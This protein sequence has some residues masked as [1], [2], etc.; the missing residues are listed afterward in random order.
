M[1]FPK[2]FVYPLH[3][4][5]NM[6]VFSKVYKGIMEFDNFNLINKNEF[7]DLNKRQRQNKSVFKAEKL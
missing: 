3:D 5:P 4:H 2:G 6:I 1:K 7:Y